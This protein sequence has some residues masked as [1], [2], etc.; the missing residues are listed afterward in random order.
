MYVYNWLF[1]INRK[2]VMLGNMCVIK[3]IFILE[4]LILIG[5][6]WYFYFGVFFLFMYM[7][8]VF[9]RNLF[10][11]VWNFKKMIIYLFFMVNNLFIIKIF[12]FIKFFVI[13][14]KIYMYMYKGDVNFCVIYKVF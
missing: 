8:N 4:V 1:G 6:L 9:E 14:C 5:F 10:W 7:K 2:D 13:S 3:Y 11:K 12:N